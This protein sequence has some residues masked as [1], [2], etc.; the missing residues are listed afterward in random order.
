M[1]HVRFFCKV[2]IFCFI[3]VTVKLTVRLLCVWVLPMQ[4]VPKMIH[5]VSGGTLNPTHSLMHVIMAFS[6]YFITTFFR[7]VMILMLHSVVHYWIHSLLIL[8]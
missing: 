7:C 8:E 4:V 1:F 2:W 3:V 6:L 5:T